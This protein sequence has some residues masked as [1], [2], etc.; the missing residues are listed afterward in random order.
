MIHNTNYLKNKFVHIVK[1]N[2]TIIV[3]YQDLFLSNQ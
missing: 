1:H 2:K 3:H